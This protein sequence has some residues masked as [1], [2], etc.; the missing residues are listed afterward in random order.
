MSWQ[1]YHRRNGVING[2]LAE[3]CRSGRAVIPARWG[4]AIIEAFGDNE[5]FLAALHYRWLNTLTARLDAVFGESTDDLHATVQEVRE[6]LAAERPA[7]WALLAVHAERP[8]LV[9]ARETEQQRCGWAGTHPAWWVDRT[10]RPAHR[11]SPHPADKPT[12][13]FT[14]TRCPL[15]GKAA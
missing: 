8:A 14:L 10:A 4:R 2:V 6:N 12:H 3:V 1:D 15:R 5:A 13:Q 11:T 9:T 7:L